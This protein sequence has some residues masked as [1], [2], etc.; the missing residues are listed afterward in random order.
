MKL[1]I[2]IIL[3]IILIISSCNKTSNVDP[4]TSDISDI[5]IMA[6]STWN[7]CRVGNE[8]EA[9]K[10]TSTLIELADKSAPSYDKG[11]AYRTAGMVYNHLADF[12]NALFYYRKAENCFETI[13]GEEGEKGLAKTWLNISLVFIMGND[14][15]EALSYALKGI[16]IF[17]KYEMVPY[18]VNGYSKISH[19]YMQMYD[20][21]MANVYDRKLKELSNKIDDPYSKATVLVNF[22]N[23]YI[24]KKNLYLSL[25]YLDSA[26]VIAEEIEAY[27][28]LSNIYINRSIIYYNQKRYNEIVSFQ[29]KALEYSILQNDIFGASDAMVRIGK[30]FRNIGLLDSSFVYFDKAEKIA[31]S[32]NFPQVKLRIYEGRANTYAQTKQFE[33]AFEEQGEY[34]SLLETIQSEEV[35][36]NMTFLSAKYESLLMEAKVEQLQSEKSAAEISAKN[37]IIIIWASITIAIILIIGI[38]LIQKQK[39]KIAEQKA[40]LRGE[41]GERIRVAREI[42]DS[43]GSML[44]VIRNSLISTDNDST[45][46]PKHS[47][48]LIDDTIREMRRI[49]HNLMPDILQEA[50]LNSAIDNFC[51]SANSKQIEIKYAFFGTDTR[52]EKGFEATLYRI[53]QELI[54]NSLKHSKGEHILVQLV[55]EN[56]RL[57]LTVSDDGKGFNI[58]NLAS[59]NGKGI[60]NIQRQ[61]SLYEGI[62]EITSEPK[63]GCECCLEF[64]NLK[65]VMVK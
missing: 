48:E 14:N 28:I 33:K 54:N 39:R 10:Q 21:D 22:S 4:K 16:E 59:S 17:E 56:H 12:A 27:D 2:F 26:Q 24:P 1:K 3:F 52:L 57:S 23:Y 53:A 58:K 13:G 55:Q 15:E 63:Q 44:S 31:D 30:A 37:R 43:L 51:T 20:N 6:D 32:L 49:S 36:K 42:H 5:Q 38:Y 45:S 46:H 7:L 61:V 8:E 25:K 47:L 35:R 62:M 41:E 60:K 50:G 64:N 65:K 18:L 9:I 11:D 29:K 40:S 19:I 34:L